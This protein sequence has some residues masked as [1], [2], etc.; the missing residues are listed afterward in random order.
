MDQLCLLLQ[1]NPAVAAENATAPGW[2]GNA[3][4]THRYATPWH[5]RSVPYTIQ[6]QKGFIGAL[7]QLR[8]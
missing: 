1:R 5:T 2:F 7:S 3:P 4:T 8:E 6:R